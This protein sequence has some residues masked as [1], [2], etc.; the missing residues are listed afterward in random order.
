M[1]IDVLSI[2]DDAKTHKELFD[3]IEK[4]RKLRR[5]HIRFTI[6]VSKD[7]IPHIYSE[8]EVEEDKI[9]YEHA[10]QVTVRLWKSNLDLPKPPP[11]EIDPHLGLQT[12]SEWCISA[13]DLA[14]KTGAKQ[15]LP[16]KPFGLSPDTLNEQQLRQFGDESTAIYKAK[17]LREIVPLWKR[18][19]NNWEFIF[20]RYPSDPFA[21]NVSGQFTKSY[22]IKLAE[23]EPDL[24]MD[25]HISDYPDTFSGMKDLMMGL[26]RALEKADNAGADKGKRK[27]KAEKM[28]LIVDALDKNPNATSVEIGRETGLSDSNVRQHWKGVK[29]MLKTGVIPRGSKKDGLIVCNAPSASCSIC[30]GD[31]LSE[32]FEC[33]ICKEIVSGECKTCHYTNEHP[34]DAIP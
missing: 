2:I 28:A 15:T 5:Y 19:L 23:S 16:A 22:L 26:E 34:E 20:V 33:K 18:F 14:N 31:T 3:A 21:E 24:P 11:T 25:F 8:S 12:V 13:T 27:T 9:I 29:R 4:L 7:F 1:K 32:P 30:G 17:T 10:R 6:S